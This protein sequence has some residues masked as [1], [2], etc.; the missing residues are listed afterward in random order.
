MMT[1]AYLVPGD[2]LL[3][4][5]EAVGIQVVRPAVDLSPARWNTERTDAG[6]HIAH[7]FALFHHSHQS[8]VLRVQF[9]VPVDFRVIEP[10]DAAPGLDL[11][12]KVRRPSQHLKLEGSEL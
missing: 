12:L 1:E 5:L 6:H 11:H 3:Q 2:G 9:A 4:A 10:E 8:E 7:G